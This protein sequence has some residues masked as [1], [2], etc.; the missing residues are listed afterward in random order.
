[1]PTQV[2]LAQLMIDSRD[3][4]DMLPQNYVPTA[5]SAGSNIVI[6]T[7]NYTAV[8]G[9]VIMANAAGGPFTITIPPSVS[10]V[11]PIFIKKVDATGNIVS[12]T[13][14]GGDLIDGLATQQLNVQYQA[15]EIFPDGVTNWYVF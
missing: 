3:R 4:A 8:P 5:P 6:I 12:V 10:S 14:T 13:A 9:D 1:M 15:M 7:S 11:A 2:T